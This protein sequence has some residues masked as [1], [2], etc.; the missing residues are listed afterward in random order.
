VKPELPLRAVREQG[1]VTLLLYHTYPTSLHHLR[2]RG[3]SD[4]LQ[5]TTE[6]PDLAELEPTVIASVTLHLRR[7]GALFGDTA[8]LPLEFSADEMSCR[9]TLSLTVPLTPP[10]EAAANE[11]LSLPV[12]QVEVVVTKMG[13]VAY[14]SQVAVA[15]LL[16]AWLVG[17]RR[18]VGG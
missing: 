9:Q 3:R 13:R 14:A 17:R 10:G 15:L 12:G 7:R 5:V 4:V 18:K 2:L 16:L 11:A 1:Q 6:P 8:A